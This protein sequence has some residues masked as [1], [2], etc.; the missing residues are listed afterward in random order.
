VK[1]QTAS[2]TLSCA[3]IGLLVAY[4]VP[5]FTQLGDGT[6]YFIWAKSVDAL[7]AR[8]LALN[9]ND[10]KLKRAFNLLA[11]I[12]LVRCLW[13]CIAWKYGYVT[14]AAKYTTLCLLVI[15]IILIIVLMIKRKWN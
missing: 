2:I 8:T 1:I 11:L 15:V 12:Y 10:T 4:T 14:A 9:L 5:E 3:L 7:L 6:L 13:E